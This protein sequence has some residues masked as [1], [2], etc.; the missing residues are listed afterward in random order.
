MAKQTTA[1]VRGLAAQPANKENQ[2]ANSLA[3]GRE[4]RQIKS[5]I[6]N[7]D[8]LTET[9]VG[10]PKPSKTTTK[11]G[12]VKPMAV[13]KNMPSGLPDNPMAPRAIL[14]PAHK[15][16][17]LNQTIADPASCKDA[18]SLSVDPFQNNTYTL[19]Q[20]KPPAALALGPEM[21]L[22]SKPVVGEGGFS[23]QQALAR[24]VTGNPASKSHEMALKPNATIREHSWDSIDTLEGVNSK[25]TSRVLPSADREEYVDDDTNYDDIGNLFSKPATVVYGRKRTRAI[26]ESEDEEAHANNSDKEDGEPRTIGNAGHEEEFQDIHGSNNSDKEDYGMEDHTNLGKLRAS[27]EDITLTPGPIHLNHQPS[28]YPTMEEDDD[29]ELE[30]VSDKGKSLS[31]SSLMFYCLSWVQDIKLNMLI[32]MKAA[33]QNFQ[34]MDEQESIAAS[35]RDPTPPVV[36]DVLASHRARNHARHLPQEE[37]LHLAAQHQGRLS[38]IATNSQ[39]DSQDESDEESTDDEAPVARRGVRISPDAPNPATLRF[40]SSS[41]TWKMV[42]VESKYYIQLY[43]SLEFAFPNREKHLSIASSILAER[44]QYHIKENNVEFDPEFSHTRS[45]DILVFKECATFRGKMKDVCKNLVTKEKFYGKHFELPDEGEEGYIDGAH[46]QAEAHSVIAKQVYKLQEGDSGTKWH[47]GPVDINGKKSNFAHP[48]IRALVLEFFYKK[49]D[50][51]AR[52]F[53]G[54]FEEAVPI[55]VLALA[56][57]CIYNCIDEYSQGMYIAI[58]FESNLYADTYDNILTV[59]DAIKADKYHGK[60]LEDMLRAWA[61]AGM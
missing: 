46:S 44:I 7:R 36:Q 1:A 12:S 49:K 41:G 40:Y 15:R 16:L 24:N 29:A 10:Q 37:H 54:Q 9:L 3:S 4:K 61:K 60:K 26:V 21:L 5:T 13:V 25:I 27:T 22:P 2:P 6:V 51:L 20:L 45:M 42:L 18:P 52:R 50:S 48:C 53:P 43:V 39:E 8:K 47:C 58:P 31:M 33:Q 57:I 34:D 14:Q 32:V 59:L 28:Y 11:R 35:Q 30:Y 17:K 23:M 55:R 19:H 38:N 56:A